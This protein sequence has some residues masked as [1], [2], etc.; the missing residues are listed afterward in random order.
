MQSAEY[1]HSQSKL[2]VLCTYDLL[3]HSCPDTQ[4]PHADPSRQL[5]NVSSLLW[6][7]TAAAFGV[8][9]GRG[10][11][12]RLGGGQTSTQPEGKADLLA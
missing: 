9:E 7:A 6:L 2:P 3:L 10:E 4:N 11:V 12:G 1:D 5:W 8:V